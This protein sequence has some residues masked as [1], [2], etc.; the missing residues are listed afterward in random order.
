MT[1]LKWQNFRNRGQL[2]ACQQWWQGCKGGEKKSQGGCGRERGT[3]GVLP[4][5]FAHCL[6]AVLTGQAHT[7]D[8]AVW[9][10][11]HTLTHTLIQSLSAKVNC[12]WAQNPDCDIPQWFCK[13]FPL[14]KAGQNIQETSLYYFYN[15]IQSNSYLNTN[16][17]FREI[18]E[19]RNLYA[20]CKICGQVKK[21]QFEPDMEQQTGSKLGK[22]FI[23]AV[24]CHPAYL[25][26]MQSTSCK[27]PGWM[28]HKLESR[29]PGEVSITSDM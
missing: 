18:T 17:N 12:F 4:L 23:K 6:N 13:M 2:S 1:S 27:M 21:Q 14:R 10:Q 9:N 5:G 16:F 11:T 3:W 7:A 25:T 8:P 29:L 24:Y 28:K 15:Y 26:Y 22:E 19:V 20:S